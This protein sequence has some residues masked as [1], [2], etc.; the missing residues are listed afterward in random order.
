MYNNQLQ[1]VANQVVT[2]Q[3]T[4]REEMNVPVSEPVIAETISEVE[5]QLT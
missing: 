2:K 1:L 3:P 4:D 5:T